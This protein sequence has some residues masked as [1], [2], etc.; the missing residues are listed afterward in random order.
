MPIEPIRNDDDHRVALHRINALWDAAEGTPEDAELDALVTL[1]DAYERKRWPTEPVTPLEA[2]KCFM[3]WRGA[4][5]K[6]LGDVL[7]SRSRASEILNGK[8]EMSLDHIR[9]LSKA[10][11][12]PIALLVGEAETA[13]TASTA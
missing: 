5:Q 8:R 6:D 11:S 7:G 3:E 13:D 9:R 10:W 1:V 2:L 12:I 4:T